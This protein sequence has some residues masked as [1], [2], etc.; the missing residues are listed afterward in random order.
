ML[1]AAGLIRG[2]FMRFNKG[3]ECVWGLQH[4]ATLLV[5]HISLRLN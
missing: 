1:V 3:M 2:M 5:Q 4:C